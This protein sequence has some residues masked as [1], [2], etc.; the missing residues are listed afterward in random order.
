MVVGGEALLHATAVSG[1]RREELE[2]GIEVISRE[3]GEKGGEL[4]RLDGQSLKPLYNVLYNDVDDV[5]GVATTAA[6]EIHHH[7]R[8][9]RRV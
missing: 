7:E 3:I 5:N 4:R 8:Q 2:E 6:A 9:F 1:Q